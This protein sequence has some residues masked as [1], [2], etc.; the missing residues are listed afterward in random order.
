[1]DPIKVLI[2]FGLFTTYVLQA[3]LVYVACKYI[4]IITFR[5]LRLCD[6]LLEEVKEEGI[7]LT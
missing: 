7:K 3:Y 6:E 2:T 1:M 5:V 4:K